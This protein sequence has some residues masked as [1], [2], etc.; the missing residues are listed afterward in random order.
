MLS[1]PQVDTVDFFAHLANGNWYHATDPVPFA[2]DTWVNLTGVYYARQKIE[3]W[4]N[5]NLVART[6]L[7][8]SNL[9]D[10]WWSDYFYAGFGA[11]VESWY[12][13]SLQGAFTGTIDE[14]RIY[15]CLPD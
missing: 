7:A 10:V 12:P 14:F 3:L 6:N 9:F 5:G 11:Y 8:D 15:N 4:V 13:D 1:E 2:Q